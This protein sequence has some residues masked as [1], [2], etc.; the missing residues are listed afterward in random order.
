MDAR[1]DARASGEGEGEG[2]KSA[3]VRVRR[4]AGGLV[5]VPRLR[6]VEVEGRGGRG[7][8]AG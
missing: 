4:T 2:V 5:Q 1:A 6:C 3:D 8:A 7:V